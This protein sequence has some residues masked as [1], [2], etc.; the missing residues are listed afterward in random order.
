[1]IC[2]AS[3]IN[4]IKMK[5]EEKE[6]FNKLVVKICIVLAIGIL[7]AVFVNL[8]GFGIPCIFH[9]ITG[10]LCPGCGI[11]RMFLALFRLDFVAAAK[12]N[13]FVLCLLPFA[14]ALSICKTIEYVKKGSTDITTIEKAFYIIVFILCIVF[15][16]L[17]N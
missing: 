11:T 13:L 15:T 12:H 10:L 16:I 3:L 17:R 7:Y 5:L 6:R 2:V 1:M 4:N 9:S 8:T 14:I